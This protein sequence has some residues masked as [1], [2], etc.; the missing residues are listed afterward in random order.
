MYFATLNISYYKRSEDR[1]VKSFKI[2]RL[3]PLPIWL[4]SYVFSQI[5][6]FWSKLLANK[7]KSKT[8]RPCSQ[9]FENLRCKEMKENEIPRLIQNSSEI[10]RL[11][12]KFP[13]PWF[14]RV[15]F[16]T[17]T[18]AND[19]QRHNHMHIMGTFIFSFNVVYIVY[20][21]N[22]SARIEIYR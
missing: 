11:E 20:W 8:P 1:W 16:A 22:M 4:L 10:S 5:S 15:P 2:L 3:S 6:W 17:P 18:V 12:D 19:K 9:K 14:F 21:S 13:R 7:Q